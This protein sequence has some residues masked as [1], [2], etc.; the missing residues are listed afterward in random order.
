MSTTYTL[1]DSPLPPP[2]QPRCHCCAYYEPT[3]YIDS[4]DEEG[5]CRRHAPRP[6]L[7]PDAEGTG[8]LYTPSNPLV[9]PHRD[10]CGDFVSA[11]PTAAAH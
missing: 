1:N 9:L 7:D 3:A 11:K 2:A 4:D 5:I 6:L 8:W 10:W